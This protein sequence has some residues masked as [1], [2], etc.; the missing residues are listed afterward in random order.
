MIANNKISK[1]GL[2][3]VALAAFLFLAGCA[4]QLAPTYDKS[5]VDGLNAA[6]TDTMTLLALV[7][8]G[9]KPED[10]NSRAEKYATLIGKLDSLTILAGARPMPKNKVSDVVNKFLEKRGTTQ[11]AEDDATP[12]SVHAI[13]KVS[14]TIEKIRNIDKKQG[15]TATEV[16]GFRG[17][18]IIYLDQA[19]TYENF[20]QR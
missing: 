16:F 19:I 9:T 12:P 1:R 4:T 3:T 2:F 14:E 8:D 7:S 17:Q 13:K 20:L 10:Y 15:V 18:V 11:I 6:N 5:V